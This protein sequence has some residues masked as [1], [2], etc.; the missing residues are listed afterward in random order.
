MLHSYTEA[1]T[2]EKNPIG[3]Q[4]YQ[5][6]NPKLPCNSELWVVT[7]NGWKLQHRPLVTIFSNPLTAQD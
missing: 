3:L 5:G 2:A 1:Q 6:L 4:V 7:C